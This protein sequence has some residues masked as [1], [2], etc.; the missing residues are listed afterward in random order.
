MEQ[1]TPPALRRLA[2]SM[3]GPG[4]NLRIQCPGSAAHG[5]AGSSDGGGALEKEEVVLENVPLSLSIADV[6]HRLTD[7][8]RCR[9]PPAAQ[10][11]IFSGE[12][13]GMGR[14]RNRKEAL[15]SFECS[16]WPPVG[17]LMGG[18][19]WMEIRLLWK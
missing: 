16:L 11:V 9:P 4:V 6:K 8:C 12:V 19:E 17:V 2:C 15:F 7:L 1:K 10:C 3:A 14:E 13:T 5:S 18:T